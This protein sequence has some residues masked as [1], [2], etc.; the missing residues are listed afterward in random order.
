[1]FAE[2]LRERGVDAEATPRRARGVTRKPERGPVRQTQERLAP[3]PGDMARVRRS[4]YQE[5]GKAAFGALEQLVRETRMAERQARVRR[6]YLAQA[7][8]LQ[9]SSD[10]AD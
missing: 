4:A 7:Q 9:R 10:L 6:F 5:A 1:M 2:K 8:V 3:G